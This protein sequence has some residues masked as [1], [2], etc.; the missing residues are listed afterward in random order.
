MSLFDTPLYQAGFELSRKQWA[1]LEPALKACQSPEQERQCYAAYGFKH[2]VE[3]DALCQQH[4]QAPK[5]WI[6]ER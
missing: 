4:G 1:E 5:M 2:E 3:F 6:V